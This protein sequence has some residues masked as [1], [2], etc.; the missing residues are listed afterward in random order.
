MARWLRSNTACSKAGRRSKSFMKAITAAAFCAGNS[1]LALK[2]PAE[3]E[4][5]ML[6]SSCCKYA[7]IWLVSIAGELP[8]A[9]MPSVSKGAIIVASTPEPLTESS[10]PQRRRSVPCTRSSLAWRVITATWSP[11]WPPT[12]SRPWRVCC[13]MAA[14]SMVKLGASF[15]TGISAK[16]AFFKSFWPLPGIESARS[17]IEL[18]AFVMEV[19]TNCSMARLSG[20]RVCGARASRPPAAIG[21]KMPVVRFVGTR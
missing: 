14:W 4:K 18:V 1:K 11:G 21:K 8:L 2:P 9:V 13:A 3:L 5:R 10:V 20:A 12:V 19:E 7:L 17:A 15:F 16:A 6:A